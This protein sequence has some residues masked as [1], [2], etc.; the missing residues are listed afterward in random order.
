M[1][2]CSVTLR[3]NDFVSSLTSAAQ[4]NNPLKNASFAEFSGWGNENG[5]STICSHSF[6]ANFKFPVD[7]RIPRYL[8]VEAG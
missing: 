7:I 2:Q 3:V 1:M 5:D 8:G 4:R 6:N